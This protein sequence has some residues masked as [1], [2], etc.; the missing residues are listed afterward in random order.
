[1]DRKHRCEYWL[2][3]TDTSLH[4]RLEGSVP[5]DHVETVATINMQKESERLLSHANGYAILSRTAPLDEVD[6]VH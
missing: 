5:R 2:Y 1:M 6:R 4:D 3:S